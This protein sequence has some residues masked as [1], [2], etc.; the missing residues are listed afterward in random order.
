MNESPLHPGGARS[1]TSHIVSGIDRGHLWLILV[2]IIVVTLMVIA[3]VWLFKRSSDSSSSS[4]AV[5]QV[6]TVADNVLPSV[7][8]ISAN[9]ATGAGTGSGEVIRS[10]GYILTNNHVISQAADGG[11]VQ[12]LFSD[13]T[14]VDATHHRPRSAD[15]PGGVDVKPPFSLA[16]IAI[17]S[18]D[19]VQ[20]GPA[21]GGAGR[22]AGAL[23]Y[24]HL[25]H[26]QRA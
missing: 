17:G 15:R 4:S 9:G 19:D 10:D 11:S 16:V 13:G 18:S 20:V 5:C 12:V 22:A 25:R 8:T 21:R 2:A 6:A 14:S 24:R 23:R 3:A 26:R 1:W 7:V